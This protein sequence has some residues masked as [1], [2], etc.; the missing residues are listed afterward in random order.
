VFVAAP[1]PPADEDDEACQVYLESLRILTDDLPP[2]AVVFN[3]ER[4]SFVPTAM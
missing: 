2:S 4:L 1:E 3:G